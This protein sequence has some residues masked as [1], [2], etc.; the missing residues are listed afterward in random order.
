MAEALPMDARACRQ[1]AE[2]MR[3]RYARASRG[4][5]SRLLDEFVAVTGYHRKYAIALGQDAVPRQRPPG[6][7]RA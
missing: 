3:K 1:S 4:E 7:P 6:A 5:R 2:E